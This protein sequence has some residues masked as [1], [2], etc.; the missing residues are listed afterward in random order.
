LEQCNIKLASV[1]SDV[2]GVSDHAMLRAL[3]AGETNPPADGQPG[4]EATAE[5][6]PGAATGARGMSAAAPSFSLLSD[7]LEELDHIGSKIAR[8]E[9]T[10]GR[11]CAP[12]RKRSM[13]G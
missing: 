3:A 8:V 10:I 12:I 7:M 13:P 1:A 11:R 2:L 9:Q 5:E 4:Q 6:D